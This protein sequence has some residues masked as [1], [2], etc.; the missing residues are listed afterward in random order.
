MNRRQLGNGYEELAA[1]YLVRQGYALL[2]RNYHIRQGEIDIIARD[3]DV[4]CF[5]EV[6]F[7]AGMDHGGAAEAVNRRKQQ[8]IVRVAQYYLMRH[9]YDEWTPCRFD[10]LAIDG[11]EIALIKNAYEAK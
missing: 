5:V 3:G 8:T 1:E 6:K 10:V 9:G 11:K 4:L 2:E 7:R